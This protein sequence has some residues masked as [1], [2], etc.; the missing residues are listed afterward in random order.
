[1]ATTTSAKNYIY[2]K[3][4][5]NGCSRS[6]QPIYGYPDETTVPKYITNINRTAR[7]DAFACSKYKV[8][9]D[10]NIKEAKIE[11]LKYWA[12]VI[13]MILLTVVLA[14]LFA[15]LLFHVYKQSI[16]PIETSST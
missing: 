10:G 9:P 4:N 1:M 12:F 14:I 7:Y 3:E 11:R 13:V 15:Y 5:N 2:N 16:I 6:M 8:C